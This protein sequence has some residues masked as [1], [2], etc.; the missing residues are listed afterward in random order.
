MTLDEL[1]KQAQA[2]RADGVPGAAA[3]L[4]MTDSGVVPVA[5]IGDSIGFAEPDG[6]GPATVILVLLER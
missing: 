6:G 1:I 3:V 2:L 5:A 4:L